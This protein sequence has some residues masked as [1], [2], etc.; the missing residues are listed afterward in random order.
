MLQ[1]LFLVVLVALG[2]SDGFAPSKWGASISSLIQRGGGHSCSTS[3]ARQSSAGN[4]G[5]GQ[6]FVEQKNFI[7]MEKME[8]ALEGNLTE[9]ALQYVNFCDESFDTFLNKR[10]D[11]AETED[12]R[13]KLGRVRYEINSARQKKMIEADK[14][15][16]SI[17][18][19]GGLKQMEAKLAFHLRKAE[20]DMAFM[21]ILQ[22]NIEDAINNKVEKAVQI[23]THLET[24]INEHQDKIVSAPVRLLRLLLRTDDSNVRKQMLRQKL[25]IGEYQLPTAQ[26]EAASAVAPVTA[27]DGQAQPTMS[28]QCEHIVV[29]AVQS[30]GSAD[31]TVQQLRD[32]VSD[33]LAQMSDS[34]GEQQ[35]LKEMELRCA[36]LRLELQEVV[37]ELSA[38]RK[39]EDLSEDDKAKIVSAEAKRKAAGAL[40]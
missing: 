20:I 5:F 28:P 22:L 34:G 17:L 8:A 27:P 25:M 33:V 11:A 32:T 21:V 16:R 10:V 2:L 37:D 40:Q 31:V 30:W 24:L 26:V 4:G 35:T 7:L 14:I 1:F 3:T 12:R 29:S 15:L 13:E 38:A 39:S 23:M 36:D 6:S 9:A 18:S 19:A